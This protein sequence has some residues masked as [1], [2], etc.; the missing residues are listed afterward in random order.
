M[1]K[2]RATARSADAVEQNRRAILAS[3]SYRLAELDT[4]F[5]GAAEQRP[6]RMQLELLK[7]ETILRENRI[8]STVVVFGSTKIVP[9]LEAERA[10]A[11][12]Q[13]RLA[14]AGGVAEAR[15]CAALHA[16]RAAGRARLRL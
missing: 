5:I 4:D 12:A 10:L 13:G 6:I 11:E 3:P 14:A 16:A 2:R 9:R 1:S 15:L 8:R 7:A